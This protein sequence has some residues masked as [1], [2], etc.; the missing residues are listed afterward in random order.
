[1][2]FESGTFKPLGAVSASSK[3]GREVRDIAEGLTTLWS[4]ASQ[5]S[6][7]QVVGTPMQGQT[8]KWNAAAMQWQ[9]GDDLTAGGAAADGTLQTVHF[10]TSVAGEITYAFSSTVGNPIA[11]KFAVFD[12]S[13]LA[14]VATSG[15]YADLSN[16][17]TPFS[18]SYNDLTDKPTIPQPITLLNTLPA[19]S[20]MSRSLVYGDNTGANTSAL[21]LYYRRQASANVIHL[22]VDD[23]SRRASGSRYRAFGWAQASDTSGNHYWAA[24]YDSA[25]QPS[26]PTGLRAIARTFDTQAT[27]T[28][29]QNWR[30][31]ADTSLFMPD[32]IWMEARPVGSTGAYTR[33]ALTKDSDGIHTSA[34]FRIDPLGINAHSSYDIRFRNANNDQV[35]S[36][37]GLIPEDHTERIVDETVLATY[38]GDIRAY[39]KTLF[40]SV[41]VTTADIIGA[42]TGTPT[43]T[44]N[45]IQWQTGGTLVWAADTGGGGNTPPSQANIYPILKTILEDS[46]TVIVIE[47]DAQEEI[48]FNAPSASAFDIDALTAASP[49]TL[50]NS[51]QLAIYDA[52]AS[53]MRKISAA[54]AANYFQLSVT[55]DSGEGSATAA[56]SLALQGAGVTVTNTGNAVTAT[57]PGF[58]GDYNDLTNR[59]TIPAA[60]QPSD[61]NATT[62]PTRI[63]NKPGIPDVSQFITNTAADAAYVNVSGDTMTGNLNVA[64]QVNAGYLNIV[65]GIVNSQTR[66]ER[67]IVTQNA[68]GIQ[69]QATADGRYVQP[70]QLETWAF[71]PGSGQIQT[72]KLPT[73]VSSVG[74]TY[75][76]SNRRLR[77]TEVNTTA[78]TF[79]RDVTLPDWQTLSEVTTLIGN[80]PVVIGN[81]TPAATV[82]LTKIGI[83]STVYSIPQ[84]GTGDDTLNVL[85]GALNQDGTNDLTLT[86]PNAGASNVQDYML[87]YDRSST[88]LRASG[89]G[90]LASQIVSA[91]PASANTTLNRIRISGVDY[92]FPTGG[93]SSFTALSDTPS[94]LGTVGQFVAVG[95]SNSLVFAN[96]PMG[97]GGVTSFTGLSDTVTMLGAGNTLLSMD[98]TGT[99]IGFVARSDVVAA[100]PSGTAAGGDLSKL[101]VNGTIFSIGTFAGGGSLYASGPTY[102]SGQTQMSLNLSSALDD[103]VDTRRYSFIMPSTVSAPASANTQMHLQLSSSDTSAAVRD[104]DGT[105]LR[106]GQVTPNRLYTLMWLQ[107]ESS[108]RSHRGRSSGGHG[109]D[110]EHGRERVRRQ[111]SRQRHQRAGG[112]GRAG[113]PLHHRT[114][115]GAGRSANQRACA[116][117]AD[118]SSFVRCLHRHGIQ[119]RLPMVACRSFV[120]DIQLGARRHSTISVCSRWHQRAE[121]PCGNPSRNRHGRCVDGPHG[122]RHGH[123]QFCDG[124]HFQSVRPIAVAAT[125]GKQRLYHGRHSRRDA[126]GHSAGR[127][128]S[129][130]NHSG[131]SQFGRIE[132]ARRS[133]VDGKHCPG[134]VVVHRNGRL[135]LRRGIPDNGRSAR[136]NSALRRCFR[137]A[138]RF[139]KRG[140]CARACAGSEQFRFLA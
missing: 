88:S 105:Q 140:R 5:P 51:D 116:V 77:L 132:R 16:T 34:D 1:M 66:A 72:S 119:Q 11:G 117:I 69:T 94:A 91:N 123:Q 113:Q 98:P 133:H 17:P 124:R 100:N 21:A 32:N 110:G 104:I 7:I 120:V 103:K 15:S 40:D 8:I 111:H 59:P 108:F 63:L 115:S 138:P 31:L 4:L 109:H 136:Q 29:D 89:L 93:A 13:S 71:S 2:G 101:S 47:N 41:T 57:I 70:A 33:I 61:W 122:R 49:S 48:S 36:L 129:T 45:R 6:G 82:A 118:A 18:G 27:T 58:S 46:G 87:F 55:G 125:D 139:H 127:A 80:V 52:S 60:Q 95:P 20:S 35:S 22:R 26:I 73:L 134:N 106:F 96:A 9:P 128:R 43:G 79:N 67:L 44:N 97:G 54:V 42:V 84:G 38:E 121:R 102:T 25:V 78:T 99:L 23:I 112:A 76:D 86:T 74:I 64:A 37:I 114:D 107:S 50:A 65:G 75:T 14:T 30:I 24:G 10:D 130:V 126:S 19:T 39:A 81:P 56:Q 68:L 131:F 90:D 62:G 28:D 53:A 135:A 137:L 85:T 83:G 12:A 3:V 92:N